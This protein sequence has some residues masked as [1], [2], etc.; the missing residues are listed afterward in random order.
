MH[1]I[2][3]G[4]HVS[5][6][7]KFC[8]N[9]GNSIE[10]IHADKISTVAA[11]TSFDISRTDHS[12]TTIK[13]GNCGYVGEGEKARRPIFTILAWMCV[14]FAPLI[15]VLYFVGTH[16]YCCPNCKSTF[17][18]IKNKES[19][20]VGQRGGASRVIIAILLVLV[21]IAITGILASIVLV[22]LQD[23]RQKAANAT[24]SW[25]SFS[26]VGNQFAVS[27]PTYPTSSSKND[28]TDD[29]NAY[30]YN[31]YASKKGT[32][33]FD[34]IDYVYTNRID[35]SSPESLLENLLNAFNN[36][37]NG[38]RIVSSEY[39]TQNGYTALDFL[40]TAGTENVRGRMVLAGQTPYVI[41][42]DYYSSDYVD[43]DYQK[44][45]NSFSLK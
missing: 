18:G 38:A 35:V 20:F 28:S 15:T 31:T 7:A 30:V 17:V 5:E 2:N 33:S 22:S 45:I 43:A 1:C 3:C 37:I 19:I 6:G 12:K 25:V 41:A 42:E 34:V 8:K 26:P 32:S 29:G 36:G 39:T 40:I 11:E 16:K 13:C 44:F 14:V 4:V 23:A 27:F 9:C 21:G 10:S 24:D